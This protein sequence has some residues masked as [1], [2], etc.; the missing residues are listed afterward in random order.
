VAHHA[1]VA[2]TPPLPRG[3]RGRLPAAGSRRGL[4]ARG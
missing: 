2:A 4:L 1:S 3:A